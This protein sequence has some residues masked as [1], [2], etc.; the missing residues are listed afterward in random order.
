VRR[1]RGCRLFSYV[2]FFVLL[3]GCLAGSVGIVATANQAGAVTPG[4]IVLDSNGTVTPLGGATYL[5]SVPA[6]HRHRLVALA[7]AHGG[8][9]Y[10]V[11]DNTG[12]IYSFGTAKYYSPP[13]DDNAIVAMA[14]TPDS[15]GYWL[16][17]KIGNIYSFGDAIFIGSPGGCC[18]NGFVS[19]APT[20]DGE[21][22]W[23]L[24]KDGTVFTYNA[25][26]YGSPVGTTP[27]SPAIS[28]EP[29]PD[30]HGYWIAERNGQVFPYGDAGSFHSCFRACGIGP[31]NPLRAMASTPDGGGYWLGKFD[32]GTP[33]GDHFCPRWK[34]LARG[35][36]R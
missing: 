21:G 8:S 29:T 30:G 32:S 31:S 17:D 10:Y 6:R 15:G 18:G 19:L 13:I 27:S 16:M 23:V 1:L 22:Y 20:P 36:C 24:N 25:P 5:G 2:G 35:E 4:L 7:V 26:F 9:G 33:A 12:G 3:V 34:P 28:I 11:A 14:V